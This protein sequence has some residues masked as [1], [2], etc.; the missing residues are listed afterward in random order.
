MFRWR[1]F[2]DHTPAGDNW[3]IVR[4]GKEMQSLIDIWAK[5]GKT[6]IYEIA[7]HSFTLVGWEYATE[8]AYIEIEFLARDGSSRPT[9]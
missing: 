5:V 7:E 9:T 1:A 4:T 6:R 3:S 2:D 8:L